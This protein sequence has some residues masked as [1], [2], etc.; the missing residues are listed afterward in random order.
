M[1]LI[2]SEIG[3]DEVESDLP[4][5]NQHEKLVDRPEIISP[6]PVWKH[7]L[8]LAFLFLTLPVWL[9]LMCLIALGIKLVSPGPV[10]FPAGTNWLWKTAIRL[11]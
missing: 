9:P 5:L 7:L 10:F 4:N 6:I 11:S 8:D 2:T 3:L 1:L